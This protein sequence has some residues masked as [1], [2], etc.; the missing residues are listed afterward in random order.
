[1][2]ATTE[3]SPAQSAPPL[4]GSAPCPEAGLHAVESVWIDLPD[5]RFPL[6]GISTG[7]RPRPLHLRQAQSGGIKYVISLCAP[8]E[9][10]DYDEGNMARG[11][12]MRYLSIP[13]SGPP[14][15]TRA[16]AQRLADALH[17][18]EGSPV[19]V[20][21]ASGNRVGA[22]FAL[23]AH[24]VDHLPVEQ[25]VALGRA[26]GLHTLESEVRCILAGH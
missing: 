6:Q 26:A 21:C 9:A 13:I 8:C 3:F 25:A 7:G 18:A 12:G 20:H 19:L 23:K 16:N 11:L 24:F 5:I 2:T 17:E 14:D 1:M 4:K 15:L 10:G 22:L